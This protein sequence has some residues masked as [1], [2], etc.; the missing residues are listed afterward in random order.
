M[1]SGTVLYFGVLCLAREMVGKRLFEDC[2]G[3]FGSAG[4]INGRGML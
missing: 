2:D 4:A 3:C 1:D